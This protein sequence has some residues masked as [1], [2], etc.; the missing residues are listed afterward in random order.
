MSRVID[1]RGGFCFRRMRHSVRNGHSRID[2]MAMTIVVKTTRNDDSTANPA[3]GPMY[4]S[5]W[6][7]TTRTISVASAS[8]RST[9]PVSLRILHLRTARP[10]IYRRATAFRVSCVVY[11]SRTRAAHEGHGDISRRIVTVV[12]RMFRRLRYGAPIVVVSGLPRSGTSMAMKMLDAGGLPT[13]V[14]GIRTA[15]NS[16]PKGYYEFERVKELDKNGD[17]AWLA[18]ARG[19]AV[20]II[21]FLLTF[22]PD[23]FQYQVIIMQRDLDEVLASQNKMLASRGESGGTADDQTMRQ[24]YQ[25]HLDKVDRFLRSRRC[26][27]TLRVRYR[28]A[29][30]NPALEA[31]RMNEFL[32]GRLKVE[33]MAAVA[34]R[35]LYRN[36]KA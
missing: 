12:D 30:D 24:A 8:Q 3:P 11:T 6:P 1:E 25:Q 35:E 15:D 31:R 13:L 34:D 5:A 29:I 20:K 22:L 33:Q 17:T 21:S 36:R 19:K 9:E 32:G 27:T 23:T 16:N 26:F 2:A 7:G 10:M 4:A 28:D 14:D 18:D